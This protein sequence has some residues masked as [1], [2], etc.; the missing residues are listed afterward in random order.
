MRCKIQSF[1]SSPGPDPTLETP[2]VSVGRASQWRSLVHH[3]CSRSVSP[4]LSDDSQLHVPSQPSEGSSCRTQTM[5]CSLTSRLLSLFLKHQSR[6][7]KTLFSPLMLQ[8][9]A[10]NC[11]KQLRLQVGTLCRPGTE[12]LWKNPV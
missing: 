1:K 12:M 7:I 6:R 10:L 2:S 8:I 5:R 3:L 9:A 4:R 11:F